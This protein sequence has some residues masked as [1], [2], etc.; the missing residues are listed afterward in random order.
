[1]I[2]PRGQQD[3][4]GGGLLRLEIFCC[5]FRDDHK[6]QAMA[7]RTCMPIVCHKVVAF[8]RMDDYAADTM[9]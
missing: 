6:G 5:V 9:S 7:S 2:E 4:A 1:M 3:N 8:L